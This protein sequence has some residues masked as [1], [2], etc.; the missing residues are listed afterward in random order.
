[1]P[2]PQEPPLSGKQG[3]LS[4]QGTETCPTCGTTFIIWYFHFE[5]DC[6]RMRN[7]AF[8]TTAEFTITSKVREFFTSQ[9]WKVSEEVKLRGRIADIVATRDKEIAAVEVKGNLGDLKLGFEQTLHYKRAANVAYLAVPKEREDQELV[10]TC[11]SLGIG[12]LLVNGGVMEAVKPERGEGL[13]SVQMAILR[14]RPKSRETVFLKSPLERL[15]RSR[16]QIL[17]LKLLFVN[18]TSKFHLNDIARK[19]GVSPSAVVKECALLLSLALVKRSAQGNLRLYEINRESVIYDEL[20]RIFL[21]Y[22]FLD[23]LFASRLRSERVKYALIYGSFAKGTEEEGSDV[24]LLVV[25]DIEEDALL[26]AVNEVERKTGR[27]VNYN[28]WTE[29]E[30]AEKVG[31]QIPLL[32]EISKTPVI[33]IVGEES[34]L[35]RAIAQRTS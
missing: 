11:R 19:T 21:K 8:T 29:S 3:A 15:F 25:A 9:G 20:K 4:S 16:T 27:E 33:M 18:P 2:K 6:S 35:K 7:M 22:E 30:F 10:A 23:E 12:L 34:G 31:H 5:N 28:L 1:L 32:R 26:K 17:I 24:D 13:A 14:P